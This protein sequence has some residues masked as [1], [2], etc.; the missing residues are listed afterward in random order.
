[1]SAFTVTDLMVDYLASSGAVAC[2]VGATCVEASEEPCPGTSGCEGSTHPDPCGQITVVCE[3]VTE[4]GEKECDACTAEATD[5]C[6]RTDDSG[7]PPSGRGPSLAALR[8]EL[9]A[10]LLARA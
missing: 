6:I 5:D 1:M 10:R 3:G 2:Q 4:D 7:D 8:A 9:E